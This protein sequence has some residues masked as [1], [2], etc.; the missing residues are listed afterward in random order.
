MYSS[1]DISDQALSDP[2]RSNRQYSDSDTSEDVDDEIVDWAVETFQDQAE[3]PAKN[4][5]DPSSYE[6][7]LRPAKAIWSYDANA[8]DPSEITFRKSEI[9]EVSDTESGWWRARKKSGEVGIVPG[10]YMILIPEL[11]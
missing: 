5:D 2:G 9:F 3:I 4:A 11:G 7:S 8:T 1:R 6:I 10:N